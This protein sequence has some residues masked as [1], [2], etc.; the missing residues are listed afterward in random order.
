[1]LSAYHL[2]V[3]ATKRER[4]VRRCMESSGPQTWR[5]FLESYLLV[6][7]EEREVLVNALNVNYRTLEGWLSQGRNPRTP[8]LIFPILVSTVAGGSHRATLSS[9]I[10][11]EFPLLAPAL[12]EQTAISPEI[13]PKFFEKVMEALIDSSTIT[14]LPTV[15]S[16]VMNGLLRHLD[17]NQQ[18]LAIFVIKCVAPPARQKVQALT[19]IKSYQ[20]RFWRTAP[21]T[22]DPTFLGRESLIGTAMSSGQP[23]IINNIATPSLLSIYPCPVPSGSLA[24]YP[25]QKQGKLAACL[26]LISEYPGFFTEIRCLLLEKY[27]KTAA[28]AFLDQEYFALEDI[29]LQVF[30]ASHVQLAYLLRFNEQVITYLSLHPQTERSVAE[31]AVLREMVPDD[32]ERQ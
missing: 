12:D 22:F 3:G 1:M 7:P 25:V 8:A 20:S 10:L 5:N 13:P 29:D 19:V 23:T 31:L 6:H 18:G 28:L 14:A 4:N 2:F 26:L 32:R 27:I 11:E 17:S 16:I 21:L 15:L 9:L 30:S 24:A